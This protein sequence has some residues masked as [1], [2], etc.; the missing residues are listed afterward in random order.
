MRADFRLIGRGLYSLPEAE[1]LTGVPR[2]RIRRWTAG[3]SFRYRGERIYSPPVVAADLAAVAGAPAID[4][5]DL[6]EVRFLDAFRRHGVSMPAIRLAAERAKELL[7]RHHPFSTKIFKTDGRTIMAEIVP[8]V[9]DR[10]LLDLVRNQ[11]AFEKIVAPYLY[12]GIEFNRLKEPE[13][14]WPLGEERRVVLDPHRSFGAPICVEGV[15]TQIL[16]GSM[17]AEEN[18][19]VVSRLYEVSLDSVN[20]ALS[21]EAHPAA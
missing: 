20:D 9:G 14:W 3:Y 8:G 17:Q 12:E 16:A 15:P 10:V 2:S 19:A 4:F 6:L 13:R 7:G 1:R 5:A 11:F 18:A 21:F